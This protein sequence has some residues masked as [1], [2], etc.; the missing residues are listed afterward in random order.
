MTTLETTVDDHDQLPRKDAV[1][2]CILIIP[3]LAVGFRLEEKSETRSWLVQ[4]SDLK[5]VAA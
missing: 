1:V 5:Y 4:K 3:I 2:H